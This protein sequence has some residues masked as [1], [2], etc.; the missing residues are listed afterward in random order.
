MFIH[1]FVHSFVYLGFGY[2]ILTKNLIL[3]QSALIMFF[4]KFAI[5]QQIQESQAETLCHGYKA[6]RGTTIKHGNPQEAKNSVDELEKLSDD[7]VY[8][9][10]GL[11]R[12][13]LRYKGTTDVSCYISLTMAIIFRNFIDNSRNSI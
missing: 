1:F 13:L 10:T 4:F 7:V 12:K 5:K 3:I 8:A 11:C 2:E 6:I 9:A